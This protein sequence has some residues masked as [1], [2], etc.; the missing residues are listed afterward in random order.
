[1]KRTHR[2]VIY[3]NESEKAAVDEYCSRFGVKSISTIFR[4]A[5]MER[6][7]SEL[8]GSHPTLF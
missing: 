8:D 5:T 1:M 3:L 6:I 7:L 4:E 2:Q